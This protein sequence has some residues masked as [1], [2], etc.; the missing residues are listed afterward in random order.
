MS[1]TFLCQDN[2]YQSNLT[3]FHKLYYSREVKQVSVAVPTFSCAKTINCYKLNHG[4][5]SVKE[6]NC[7]DTI[8]CY[9]LYCSIHAGLVQLL[10]LTYENRTGVASCTVGELF[11]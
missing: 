2:L 10:L 11:C 4:Q 6:V 9:T 7:L 1:V 3:T 5:V 8:H